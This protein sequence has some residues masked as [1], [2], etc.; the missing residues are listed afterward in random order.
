MAEKNAHR[1]RRRQNEKRALREAG[2]WEFAHVIQSTAE[3]NYR[4]HVMRLWEHIK[5]GD[6]IKSVVT[7]NPIWASVF[8]STYTFRSLVYFFSSAHLVIPIHK[9]CPQ[10]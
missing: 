8:R 4:F 7:R 3:M 5:C 6:R 9:L 2:S 10:L 1:N